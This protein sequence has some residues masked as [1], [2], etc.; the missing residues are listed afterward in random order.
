M[1]EILSALKSVNVDPEVFR[2]S[3]LVLIIGGLVLVL[4]AKFVFGLKSNFAHGL[5]TAF[6]ILFV[7]AV[8]IVV[9]SCYPTM[10]K[11]IPALPFA[12]FDGCELII[13]SLA[14]QAYTVICSHLLSMI[15]LAFLTNLIDSLLPRSKNIIL[16]L[17]VKCLT[18]IGSILLQ[19]LVNWLLA[20]YLPAGFTDLAPA[21]LLG[22]LV[23]LLLIG[24]SKFIV[25]ALL[26]TV[27]PLIG[28]FYSF[29]FATV[30]GKAI[31]RSVI[32]TA[33]LTALVY[34]LGY[35]GCTVISIAAAALMA[36]IPLAILLALIWY[37]TNK[38]LL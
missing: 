7:Y 22:I 4:L 6:G 38:V 5:S 29:F 10:T 34:L 14:G 17:L 2:D 8:S 33:I 31:T 27:H 30:V 24:V 35:V 21:I 19:L 12:E 36:Y 9:Y 3:S 15:I 23:F 28:I 26:T 1:E 16:W 32:A 20:K 13:F 18:V 37:L 11:Y 25:G